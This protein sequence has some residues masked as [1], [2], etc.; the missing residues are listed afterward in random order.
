MGYGE[1]AKGAGQGAVG[2]ALTGAAFG[3]VVP[4]VGTAIGAGAGALLGGIGGWMGGGEN[5]NDAKYRSMLDQYYAEIMNRQGPQ[6]GPASQGAYS[7]FRNNQRDMIRRLEAMSQGKGPSYA[8]MQFRQATDQN[9]AAQSAMAMSGR[10]GPM[11]SLNAAN[12]MG[13]LGTQAAQGS[14]MARVKEMEMAQQQLGLSLHSAR[15]MD[16][17]MNQFNANEQN[18]TALANLEARLRAMGMGDQARLQILQQ[19]G[20]FNTA[21]NA[22][23]TFGEQLLAGGAGAFG[24]YMAMK[25]G[26]SGKV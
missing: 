1:N 9:M 23:P 11:A 15:G 22:Q 12:N 8:G 4:G 19:L 16:E 14:A 26:S 6:A 7:G 25:G 21:Q 13:M 10:G 20:G 2:G 5:D 24:Q 3:S 18:Q 17:Q